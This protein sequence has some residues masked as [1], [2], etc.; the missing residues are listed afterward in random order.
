MECGPDFAP[1]ISVSAWPETRWDRVLALRDPAAREDALREVCEVYRGV[2]LGICRRWNEQDGE[3]LAHEFLLW[4]IVSGRLEQAD[5]ARGRFRSYVS[6]MLNNF[7]RKQHRAGQALKRGGGAEHL[8]WVEEAVWVEAAPDATFDQAWARALMERVVTALRLE[9][10]ASGVKDEVLRAVLPALLAEDE[11]TVEDE[12]WVSMA[13]RVGIS[14]GT[15]RSQASRLRQRFR[16]LL[17]KEVSFF[18]SRSEVESEIR[19]LVRALVTG[20]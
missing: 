12:T 14:A 4:V 19:H 18:T 7:L 5:S 16:E 1:L 3:D 9:A 10:T 20:G 17:E 13:S 8:D 2:I 15:L 11:E 6:T